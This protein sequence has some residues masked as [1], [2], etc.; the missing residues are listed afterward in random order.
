MPRVVALY[1]YP[2]K[3]FT[4]E[5][6]QALTVLDEGR[7]AGDRV[8]GIRYA[9]SLAPGYAWGKKHEFITLSNTSGL[10]RLKLQFDP[11]E[12]RLN[13]RLDKRILVNA[14]LDHQGRQ[15][16]AKALESYV[17]GQAENPLAKHPERLPLCVVGDGVKPQ[18]QDNTAGHI[19]LHSRESLAALNHALGDGGLDERRF[20]SNIVIEGLD[21][22]EEQSWIGRKIRIGAVIFD[23]VTAKGRCLATQ[24]NPDTGCYDLPILKTLT[25]AFNQ[26]QPTFAVGMLT[27]RTGGQIRLGDEL[28]LLD[29]G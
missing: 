25:H 23:V 20:R 22:W 19:T 6:C 3:G 2:V 18:Y 12:L 7:I 26:A 29:S 8:L 16:I 11:T 9:N 14:A 10:A 4:P 13:I 17:L 5:I 15:A 28:S 1:R 24:A 27:C 21:A